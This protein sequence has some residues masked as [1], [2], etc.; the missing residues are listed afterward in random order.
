[1]WAGMTFRCY[2]VVQT[3]PAWRF[4]PDE[5]GVELEGGGVFVAQIVAVVAGAH[6]AVFFAVEFQAAD[7]LFRRSGQGRWK[8]A[9]GADA[10]VGQV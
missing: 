4:V 5:G 6:P 2:W 7:C 9:H 8:T 10:A 3:R 1:M